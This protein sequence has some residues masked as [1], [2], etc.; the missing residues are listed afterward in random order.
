M[1]E[2]YLSDREQEEA[3][4]AWWREN[5]NWILGG[6]V[7]GLGL[8]AGY[9]YW[10][11]YTARRADEAGKLHTQFREALA[12][13]DSEQAARLLQDLSSAHERSAY[14][15]QGRL[16]LAK[17]RVDAGKFEEALPYLQAVIDKSKDQQLAEVARM[18]SAR[19]LSQL[20]KHDDALKLLDVEAAGAFAPQVRELR[21]DVY[22]AK[23]DLENARAEYAAGLEGNDD[24]RS[25]GILELKLQ[26]VGGGKSGTAVQGQPVQGQP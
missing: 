14:T 5:R 8:L 22:V 9:Q 16:Q 10:Q 25:R 7:L 23:G 12:R 20:G 17:H 1:V 13:H 21:G 26:E 6:V 11:S 18:R 2:D 19:V 15:Q 4:R 24:Q 3:L